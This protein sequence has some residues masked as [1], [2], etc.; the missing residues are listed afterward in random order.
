MFREAFWRRADAFDNQSSARSV[1]CRD[2]APTLLRS[3]RYRRHDDETDGTERP[4][5]SSR[6]RPPSE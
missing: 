3:S 1:P 5:P 2:D 6:H 4:H